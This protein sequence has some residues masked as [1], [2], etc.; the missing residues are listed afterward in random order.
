[1]AKWDFKIVG[2]SFVKELAPVADDVNPRSQSFMQPSFDLEGDKIVMKESGQYKTAIGFTQIGE[3]DGV[4]PTDLEDAYAKLLVLVE[5]FNGGGG[6]PGTTPNLDEVLEVGNV[7]LDTS[8]EI[9]NTSSSVYSTLNYNQINVFSDDKIVRQNQNGFEVND[10]ING[11][12]TRNLITGIE[13]VISGSGQTNVTF[14]TPTGANSI[15]IPNQSGTIAMLS[16][17]PTIPTAAIDRGTFSG[18]F[19]LSNAVRGGEYTPLT[20]TG[21]LTL[22]AGVNAVNGGIDTVKITANGSAITVPGGWINIGSDSISVVN[23]AV[24]RIMVRQ[25]QSEIWYAIKVN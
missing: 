2:A 8:I 3:I 17:I 16:D 10:I 18:E 4:A 19:A 11:N 6:A 12:V 5:N 7:A 24:N 9:R 23:G 13:H 22:S 21:A 25:Y 20:Q 15:I 1:M 14:E